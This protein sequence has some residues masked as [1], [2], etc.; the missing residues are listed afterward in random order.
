LCG[1]SHKN[2]RELEVKIIL[3]TGNDEEPLFF[4]SAPYRAETFSPARKNNNRRIPAGIKKKRE[5]TRL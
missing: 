3:S 2:Q 4:S 1:Y 5:K